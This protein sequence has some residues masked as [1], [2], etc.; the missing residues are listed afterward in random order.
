[1]TDSGLVTIE[2]GVTSALAVLLFVLL[3]NLLVV[4]YGL[5]AVNAALN[6]AVREGSV[7]GSTDACEAKANEVMG[8]VLGG[9]MGSGV[10]VRCWAAQGS[11][12]ARATGSFESLTAIQPDFRV[13]EVARGFVEP[14]P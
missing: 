1:M 11:V 9:W 13:D 14:W 4:Q 3:A 10:M 2:F 5:A 12:V 6:Q 8:E 7:T